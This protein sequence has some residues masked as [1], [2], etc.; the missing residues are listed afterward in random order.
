MFLSVIKNFTCMSLKLWI[1]GMT[2]TPFP[3]GDLNFSSSHKRTLPVSRQLWLVPRGAEGNLVL[4]S[5]QLNC[6]I[7]F[8]GRILNDAV[9]NFPNNQ[10]EITLVVC[11]ETFKVKNYVDDEPGKRKTA[12]V[13]SQH[14]HSQWRQLK[15]VGYSKFE[16]GQRHQPEEAILSIWPLK[17]ALYFSLCMWLLQSLTTALYM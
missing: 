8:S 10:E 4:K 9:Y 14:H 1:Q 6:G 13:Y 17:S 16:N 2:A 7:H 15:M 3:Y 5:H 12:A 11:P